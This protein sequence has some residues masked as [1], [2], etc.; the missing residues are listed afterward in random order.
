MKPEGGGLPFPYSRLDTPSYIICFHWTVFPPLRNSWYSD[1][2]L[3]A[4]CPV[5]VYH[6]PHEWQS[7]EL[8]QDLCP[9]AGSAAWWILLQA[10]HTWRQETSKLY[11]QNKSIKENLRISPPSSRVFYA[12]M[13]E[14]FSDLLSNKQKQTKKWQT[15][16]K[17]IIAIRKRCRPQPYFNMEPLVHYGVWQ[18]IFKNKNRTIKKQNRKTIIRA[19]ER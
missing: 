7:H 5:P 14:S 12:T 10:S 9:A 3:S 17:F 18:D 6:P 2:H 19:S 1:G 16:N 11:C 4:I 13:F 15:K 8:F